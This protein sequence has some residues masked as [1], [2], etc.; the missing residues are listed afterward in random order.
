MQLMVLPHFT[1]NGTFVSSF[2]PSLNVHVS[3]AKSLHIPA[4]SIPVPL[5]KERIAIEFG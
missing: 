4:I 3:I 5:Y 2:C 1:S